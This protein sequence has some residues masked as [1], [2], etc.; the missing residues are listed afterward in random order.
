[1]RFT[2]YSKPGCPYCD[3]VKKVLDLTNMTYV[4][5]TLGEN[6]FKEEFYSEFGENSTF[7]QVICDE[8][9][10]GGC[11]DTINFLKEKQILK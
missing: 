5:Y 11:V 3:K 9:K 8:Q 10:I 4:E 1:M 2:I 7:P 6:F